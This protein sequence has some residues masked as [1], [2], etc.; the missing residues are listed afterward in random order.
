MDLDLTGQTAL[1]TAAR[2]KSKWVYR[3]ADGRPLEEV[4]K[5]FFRQNQPTSQT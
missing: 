5:T 4:E 1:V 2:P 3:M